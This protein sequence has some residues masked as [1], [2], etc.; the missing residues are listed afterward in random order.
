MVKF[1]KLKED[2]YTQYKIDN[3]SVHINLQQKTA[4]NDVDWQR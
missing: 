4:L 3:A 1:T 2:L